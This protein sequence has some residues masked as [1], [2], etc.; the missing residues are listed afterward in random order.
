M[1]ERLPRMCKEGP[2]LSHSL[3]KEIC[4]KFSVQIAW[5][6]IYVCILA[7]FFLLVFVAPNPDSAQNFSAYEYNIVV[8]RLLNLE[9]D[10]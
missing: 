3:T 4:L 7:T 5:K 8:W 9:I 6:I 2:G 1:V 10:L